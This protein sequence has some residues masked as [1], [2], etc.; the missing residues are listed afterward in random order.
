MILVLDAG[1]TNMV[2]GL[3]KD[4]N[5]IADWRLSTDPFENCG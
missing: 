2:L 5:L 4:K 3:Y 1:N